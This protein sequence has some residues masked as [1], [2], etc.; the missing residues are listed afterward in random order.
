M[1][2][3]TLI[4]ESDLYGELCVRKFNFLKQFILNN[5]LFLKN[6]KLIQHIRQYGFKHNEGSNWILDNFLSIQNSSTSI[7]DNKHIKKEYYNSLRINNRYYPRVYLFCSYICNVQLGV[8]REE[9]FFKSLDNYD[10]TVRLT[11]REL[12]SIP[13]F[14]E[15]VI[16][17]NIYNVVDKVCKIECE[18]Y[19]GYVLFNKVIN[20]INSG[21]FSSASNKL[22]SLLSNDISYYKLE[23]FIDLVEENKI[24]DEN[25]DELLIK[26]LNNEGLTHDSLRNKNKSNLRDI[27]I[28]LSSYIQSLKDI[29]SIDWRVELEKVS[30]IHKE[31][32]KDPAKVYPNMD[33]ETRDEYRRKLEKICKL[34]KL[35]EYDTSVDILNLSRSGNSDYSRHVGYYLI[36][37]G[38]YRFS[39]IR[40]R[41]KSKKIL[42]FFSIGISI[43]ISELLFINILRYTFNNI[44]VLIAMSMVSLIVL[45]DILINLINYIFLSNIERKFVP[46]MDYSDVI[47]DSCKTMV[48]IPCI[49]TDKDDIKS[50]VKNL[51]ISYLC[52]RSNNLYFS[53][54]LDYKDTISYEKYKDNNLLEYATNLIDELNDKY[55]NEFIGR[56]FHLFIRDKIYSECNKVYMGWERKRGKIMEF[57][58]FLKGRESSYSDS[59]ENYKYLKNVRYLIS[60]DCDT[61]LIKDSAFK[62]I[63]AIDHVL[64][65]AI[66][67]TIKNKIRV[68][69]GYG[70][71]QPRVSVLF[72]S[73]LTT[74]YSKIF[75]G[76]TETSSYNSP[77]S[78]VYQDIFSEG[79]FIGKGIIDIDVFDNILWNVIPENRV[80][81]HDLIE[82]CFVRVAL[83]SDIEIKESFPSNILSNFMRYHRWIRGDFQLIPYLVN[84]MGISLLGKYKILDN[85]RRSLLPVSYLVMMTIPFIINIKYKNIYY[86]IVILSIIFP[87]IL[88]V[89]SL[90][91]TRISKDKLIYR[92]RYF[93]DKILQGFVM[94]AFIPY[95][96]YMTLDAIF[97]VITRLVFTKQYLL[98]WKSF[99]EVEKSINNSILYY[100]KSMFVGSII[101]FL[102]LALSIYFKIF[103]MII[104]SWMFIISPI[105]A[106][107][108]SLNCLTKKDKI[109]GDENIFFRSLSRSIFAYFEDFTSEST[110][111]LVCDNFQEDPSIGIA[112]KTSP[113][114]I[115]M[116]LNAFI[117]G[118]D[119][120]FITITDMV[121]RLGRILDSIDI[122]PSYRGHL[123]NWYDIDEGISLGDRY[124]ST[125]DS[126]NLLGSYYL[127]RE[128]LNDILNSTIIHKDLL[129]SFE[130]LSY[131]SNKFDMDHLYKEAVYRGFQCKE[132]DDYIKFLK[133]IIE[134]SDRNISQLREN[135]E[136][137]YWHIKINETANN[138]LNEIINIT[139]NIHELNNK[140]SSAIGEII[141]RTP[142]CRLEDELINFKQNYNNFSVR[143]ANIDKTISNIIDKVRDLNSRIESLKNRISSKIYS[144][145]FKFLY[146]DRNG[147]LSIGYDCEKDIL[148][149]NCYD[150]LASEVRIASFLGIAKGDIPIS[151]WFKL[152]RL[153]IKID[154]VNTLLSW[155]G[156]MF[157]YLMPMLYM[158]AYPGTLFYDTYKG[159]VS[160]Q[161]KYGNS[162]NVPFGISESCYY[163]MDND[164]NYQ[165]R[166][167]GDP[168][169]AINKDYENLVISPYS[170]IMSLGVDFNNSI[171]NLRRLK[172]LGTLGRYG[173]YESIDFTSKRLSK[174][175][176][177][178]I[179]KNY[180]A[181]HQGMSLMSLSNLL[182]NGICQ[183]RFD[184]IV[185]VES[186][187]ELLSESNLNISLKNFNKYNFISGVYG[188]LD[189]EFI[190]KIVRYTNDRI[191][192]MQILSN[193]RYSVFI[194]SSGGGGLRYKNKYISDLSY[195][196]TCEN[197]WGNIYIRDLDS[198]SLFS[199]TYLP[200]KNDDLD[201][202]CEFNCNQVKF[203]TKNKNLNVTTSVIVSGDDDIEIRKVIIKNL[204]QYDKNIELASYFH[205]NVVNSSVEYD[206][207]KNIAICGNELSNIFIGHSVYFED[208]DN[209]IEFEFRKDKFLG[210]GG[211]SRY[212]YAMTSNNSY[213]N[214][215][216]SDQTN[217][218][219]FKNKIVLGPYA[220]VSVYFL[221]CVGE[222][223]YNVMDTINRYSNLSAANSVFRNSLYGLESILNNL[224]ISYTELSLF[225]HMTSLI[226]YG[227]YNNSMELNS[228][229]SIRDIISHNINP[230]IPIVSIEVS[231]VKDIH[232]VEMMIKAH[233]Y[234]ALNG[235]N[236]NLIILNSYIRYD[237]IIENQIDNIL[238]K[239]NLKDKIN[240]DNGI[241][242]ILAN[243]YKN[244]YDIIKHVSNLHIQPGGESIFDQVGFITKD[245]QEVL[246]EERSSNT[247]KFER[248]FR[249][250]N[251]SRNLIFNK[252]LLEVSDEIS[253]YYD[254]INKYDTPKKMLKY[255]NS[256]GGFSRDYSEYIVK[257]SDMNITPNYYKNILGNKYLST[258]I[259]SGGFSSTWA[260]ECKEFM[261][262]EDII[263][264]SHEYKGECIYIKEGNMIWSP[265]LNPISN[266][267]EY[268]VSNSFDYTNI[269][270][271]YNDITTNVKC[272]IP[273]DKKYK[274]VKINIKNMSV[275]DR[276]I[277][278]SYF[279]PLSLSSC[280]DYKKRLSTFINSDFNYIYGEN[281]LS[282]NFS[283]IKSYLKLFGCENI[284]FTGSKREF[285][286]IN[287][288][289][290]DPPGMYKKSLSNL[291]GILP[292]ACLCTS[293]SISLGSSEEKDVYVILG[294]DDNIESIN[295]E[296][297][298][299]MVNTELFDILENDNSCQMNDIYR[300]FQIRTPDEYIDILINGWILH[301]N[302]NEKFL[303]GSTS[304]S[305]LNSCVDMM[306]RCLVF[307]YI[308]PSESKKNIIRV[309]SNMYENGT[310]RDKWSS[311]TKQYEINSSLYDS[312]WIMYILLDYIK[313]TEDRSILDLEINFASYNDK[314]CTSVSSS[315]IY[316]KCLKIVYRCIDLNGSFYRDNCDTST[317]FMLC[318][319][320]YEFNDICMYYK[321]DKLVN[322]IDKLTNEVIEFLN[323]NCFNGEFYSNTLGDTRG[324]LEIYLLPQV[325]SISVTNENIDAVLRSIDKYLVNRDVGF[326][327]E[328]FNKKT[329]IL[330][331]S[332]SVQNN[333]ILLLFIRELVALNLND[334]AYKYLTYLNPILRTMSRNDTNLYKGEPYIVPYKLIF[335]RNILHRVVNEDFSYVSSLFY[336]II[337]DNILGI[338]LLSNGFYLDPHIPSCWNSCS[339][340]YFK[341]E[342]SY[343]IIIRRGRL[344]YLKVNGEK[345]GD[346][347]IEFID[348]NVKVIDLTI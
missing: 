295:N 229:L 231:S 140:A 222:D 248:G 17:E 22:K 57:I 346:K 33:Y 198:N 196:Y 195:D 236:F 157:E 112:K 115:G 69:R 79:I 330:D 177:Y 153:G 90:N 249:E 158:R 51:E 192:D 340:D 200:C 150:L 34:H 10:S 123:Y 327:R 84:S 139:C 325:L 55:K 243:L 44:Y 204:T 54:L 203:T 50:I 66:F 155:S 75:C 235:L 68:V 328:Y 323:S 319:V 275:R 73:S 129:K 287:V 263:R 169:L 42:Y 95:H 273:R 261:I 188:N 100:I 74:L 207:D 160:S 241:Y 187:N 209:D 297:N 233:T 246:K 19:E 35:N 318:K 94:F 77:I 21:K 178:S 20:L 102:C 36:D 141:I 132:Y 48:V 291:S 135:G 191:S 271:K 119:F 250:Y 276:D 232:N 88:D 317:L 202:M 159:C 270:N 162:N 11:L 61:K 336:R 252:Y 56:K 138:C 9:A 259:Y 145:D 76:N 30:S 108:L 29:S 120:G 86:G 110:N 294:Y 81:S 92:F 131:L 2:G 156:T 38:S 197:S 37:K 279:A 12:W 339:I 254:Y 208:I 257:L 31:F 307:T 52:N 114:N 186:I 146:N 45:S 267:E 219:S 251:Y 237:R 26:A 347:I 234:F 321:D 165:Y 305:E 103:E 309:F 282:K 217:I 144:M 242:I 71:I 302:M 293:G 221:I 5:K 298:Q 99:N 335:K 164:L 189:K 82:G 185:D 116:S 326:V 175:E 299:L 24:K 137:V 111:Y 13:F 315:T 97:R 331:D 64:N 274:V 320:L 163:E 342:N 136:D 59:I 107:R 311:I 143:N 53:I 278:I 300:G 312:L 6:V 269:K 218:M 18:K 43:L 62:L 225:N 151:H 206:V 142:V 67:K 216:T 245:L 166:A 316:H 58:K 89:S 87:I 280:D 268:M 173:F 182:I 72:K 180:M 32:L 277:N 333:K 255:Y 91:L 4:N 154:N 258:I 224:D 194:S 130:E 214:H 27:R 220:H 63:G 23:S 171:K 256:Y 96:A 80:L 247:I 238:L 39:K 172:E 272:F 85:I 199:N 106:Y 14:L 228:K 179:V 338:K 292:E 128:S 262:T 201:Y 49:L 281:N 223:K 190:P 289:Y 285:L 70:I 184:N 343:K 46:K 168:Y 284:S 337:I 345:Y 127:C 329:S 104:P 310:F 240:S 205:S 183:D 303:L 306:E 7:L 147:L 83:S 301:Q 212:P 118:R 239:Y 253:N 283:N 8:F 266:G 215:F 308:N 260:F 288:G 314:K 227:S 167:F 341:G 148:D 296:I 98:E 334:I 40:R 47:P 16:I 28:K 344:R 161:I 264:D 126:G 152:G 332:E 133:S 113:T 324:S 170:S 121:N 93:I 124:I 134:D 3:K 181:H 176:K 322:L 125:V 265:T 304:K 25:I 101:G 286:G 244:S 230:N 213:G 105:I 313:I 210:R 41:D 117:L 122:L 348:N 211:S 290:F 65:R 109:N 226:I 60:I 174:D 15:Y 149:E 193:G 1:I 78:N